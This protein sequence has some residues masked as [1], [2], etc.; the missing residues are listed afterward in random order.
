M[1]NRIRYYFR[2]R[3]AIKRY[4]LLAAAIDAIDKAF[5][6][7]GVSRRARRQFWND[8]INNPE[9]RKKFM[10]GMWKNI[11]KGENNVAAY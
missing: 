10:E 1:L 11:L 3:K 7:N 4:K 6:R 5:T 2:V 8:F 9:S